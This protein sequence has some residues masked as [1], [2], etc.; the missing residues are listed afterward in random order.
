V[1]HA[2]AKAA[3]EMVGH[4]SWLYLAE[5]I[6]GAA[7]RGKLMCRSMFRPPAAQ[8]QTTL[9]ILFCVHRPWAAPHLTGPGEGVRRAG[10]FDVLANLGSLGAEKDRRGAP[11]TS[12]TSVFG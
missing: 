9:S 7:H 10:A 2:F 11:Q 8:L 12:R 3:D 4:V 6:E 5:I 1:Q